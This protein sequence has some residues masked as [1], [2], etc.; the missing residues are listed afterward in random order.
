MCIVNHSTTMNTPF[1]NTFASSLLV[2]MHSGTN[3]S[4]YMTTLLPNILCRKIDFRNKVIPHTIFQKTY[5]E[6]NVYH[7]KM[8]E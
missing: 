7:I 3:L 8:I 6:T 4:E 1:W 2:V 5:R